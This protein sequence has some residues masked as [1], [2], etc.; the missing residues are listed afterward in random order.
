M[1]ICGHRKDVRAVQRRGFPE[2]E[3]DYLCQANETPRRWM[4]GE[5][6]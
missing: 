2:E 4:M 5:W 3:E 6:I 1:E